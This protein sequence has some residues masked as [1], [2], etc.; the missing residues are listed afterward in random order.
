MKYKTVVFEEV[1]ILFHFNIILNTTGC[2]LLKLLIRS[3]KQTNKQTNITTVHTTTNHW[4]ATMKIILEQL[5]FLTLKI[6]KIIICII[7]LLYEELR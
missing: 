5:H 6:L 1:H 7:N 2:P 4:S 3:V